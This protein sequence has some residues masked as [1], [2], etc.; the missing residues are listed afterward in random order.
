MTIGAGVV[1]TGAAVGPAAAGVVAGGAALATGAAAG[2]AA[3]A[4]AVTGTTAAAVGISGGMISAGLA[5]SPLGP[6][7]TL[8]LC[9]D[10]HTLMD[11]GEHQKI[12][13]CEIKSG[14]MVKCKVRTKIYSIGLEYQKSG[15]QGYLSGIGYRLFL[16]NHQK[17]V[18]I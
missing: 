12:K 4:A 5:G 15:H 2:G 13:A 7:G 17:S 8:A 10:P 11:I 1:L 6:V 18:T 3:A 14:D 9:F 16:E